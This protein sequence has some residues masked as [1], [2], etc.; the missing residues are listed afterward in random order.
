MK[1][2]NYIFLVLNKINK[3]VFGVVLSILCILLVLLITNFTPLKS[4]YSINT[5]AHNIK[6]AS[7]DVSSI[8]ISAILIQD[9]KTYDSEYTWNATENED[10]VFTYQVNYKKNRFKCFL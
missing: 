5:I 6:L 2:L 1:R 9:G 4:K 10:K 8:D 7:V 3:K